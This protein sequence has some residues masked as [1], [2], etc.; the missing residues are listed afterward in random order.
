[1]KILKN[2]ILLR[3]NKKDKKDLTPL[4]Y[5]DV[6]LCSAIIIL[7]MLIGLIVIAYIYLDKSW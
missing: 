4:E 2:L 6:Q 3:L 7:V 5:Y 1:M